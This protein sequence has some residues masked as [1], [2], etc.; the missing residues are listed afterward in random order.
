MPLYHGHATSRS[1]SLPSCFPLE[2]RTGGCTVWIS[3]LLWC[4]TSSHACPAALGSNPRGKKKTWWNSY[5]C[6][7][8][9]AFGIPKR[10]LEL[11]T[12]LRISEPAEQNTQRRGESRSPAQLSI[13]CIIRLALVTSRILR[14]K[15]P[16]PMLGTLL[17]SASCLAVLSTGRSSLNSEQGPCHWIW[18][19]ASVIDRTVS[20]G[21][22]KISLT[23][24]SNEQPQLSPRRA[25]LG[26]TS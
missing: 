20:W 18:F 17:L 6:H 11:T 24:T 22:Y 5:V 4:H 12:L 23:L 8:L 14:R 2:V 3:K 21:H 1:A 19:L 7:C 15:M 26:L 10:L 9:V 16:G 13:R 25:I